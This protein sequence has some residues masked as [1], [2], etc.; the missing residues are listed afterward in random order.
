VPRILIYPADEWGCGKV[1]LEWPGEML[2]A[3][4]HL[5]VEVTPVKDRKMKLKIRKDGDVDHCHDVMLPDDVECVVMQRVTHRL[6]VE[7]ISILRSR[8][9]AV[10]VDVDDDLSSIDPQNAS[11][12]MLK[13]RPGADQSWTNLSRA[14]SRAT[15]VTCSTPGLLRRYANHGRG[16]VL[17]N[18]LADHYYTVP[19]EDS[20]LIGWAAA[21]HSHPRD[22]EALGLAVRRVVDEGARFAV[23]GPTENVGDA[24][25]LRTDPT[26][27]GPVEIE[28]WPAALST[29]GIGVVPLADT[30]FNSRKSWLKGLE[31]SAAG[32][33]WI[34]SPR[35]EYRRLHQLGAGLLATKPKHWYQQ[36][37]RLLDEPSLRRDLSA[38]GK[39]VAA[40]LSLTEHVGEYLEAWEDAITYE[41]GAHGPDVVIPANP[42]A[43]I[44]PLWQQQHG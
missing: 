13:P 28:D 2:R 30:M 27:C 29:L 25:H 18:Y 39:A 40:S 12:A 5:D 35:D 19:H 44:E 26:C 42:K 31:L 24:F 16:R 4:G 32:V 37:R 33:P 7:A 11:F 38:A 17:P 36:L 9:I 23:I 22:P 6:L 10:V 8:K 15:L 21:L 20:D 14:C 3:H 41:R 1:R 34:A 43:P